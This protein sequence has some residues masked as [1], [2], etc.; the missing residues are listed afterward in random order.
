[1]KLRDLA[2]QLQCRL[3]GA[4]LRGDIDIQR[5]AGI[6][7]AQPGDL[8]FL[9]NPAISLISGHDARLGRH[10]GR[11]PGDSRRRRARR[12]SQ[13]QAVLDVRAGGRAV[14]AAVGAGAGRRSAEQRR[15]RRHDRSRRFNRAVRHRGRGRVDWRAHDRLSRTPPSA[16][17]SASA[18][19]ASSTPTSRFATAWSSAT[20]SSCTTA[21]SSAATA[22]GSRSRPTARTSR[23]R[24][25]ADV[26]IEDDVEI[27]ANTTIDRPAVGETRIR[28]GT[29]IDNLVH[30]AHGVTRRPA[31]DVS[32]RR[33]ACRAAPSSK[34][35]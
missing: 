21:S 16:P 29:K 9:D 8:T 23:S 30:I 20:A 35:T 5:V 32:R 24:R 6:E 17:A 34:T 25:R 22:S 1:M 28:A 27:G 10:R 12:A 15:A 2:D 13:R 7:H 3:E 4:A 11:R 33:S 18:T 14:R 19:I 26:V 31:R